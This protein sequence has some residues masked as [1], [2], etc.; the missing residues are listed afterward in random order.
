[1][2]EAVV[3]LTPDVRAEEVVERGDVAATGSHYHLQPL[4]VLVEHRVDDV[5]ERLVVV[6][7]AVPARQE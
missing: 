1:M 4:R 7:D 5:D 6:E 2:G 3:V